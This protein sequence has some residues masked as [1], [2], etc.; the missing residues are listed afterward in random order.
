MHHGA[1]VGEMCSSFLDA[2]SGLDQLGDIGNN[3]VLS[4]ELIPI[5]YTV[6]TMNRRVEEREFVSGLPMN[7]HV[8]YTPQVEPM[9]LHRDQL[10]QLKTRALFNLF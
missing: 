5:Q 8:S 4:L 10:H 9:Q 6:I 7:S 1:T 3:F 2:Q